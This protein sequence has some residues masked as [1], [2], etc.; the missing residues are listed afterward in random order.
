MKYLNL[1]ATAAASLNNAANIELFG[2]RIRGFQISIVSDLNADGEAA[3]WEIST[4]PYAQIETNDAVGPLAVLRQFLTESA[5]TGSN[6][7]D[8]NVFIPIDYVWTSGSRLYL[9]AV[10]TGTTSSSCNV[11]VAY[12]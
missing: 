1:Y 6:R 2:K 5:A 3:N 7:G 9:N 11:I 10:L 4:V 12:E 8:L